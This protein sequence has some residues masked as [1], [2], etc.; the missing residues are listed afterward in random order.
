MILRLLLGL[1]VAASAAAQQ[2]DPTP[3]DPG[4]PTIPTITFTVDWEAATPPW[5]SVTVDSTGSA[6]YEALDQLAKAGDRY[7]VKF[8]V[9][10]PTRERLFHLAERLNYF[11]GDFDFKKHKIAF[12]GAKTLTYA[13]TA[14]RH[15][16][17]YVWSEN[18]ELQEVTDILTGIAATQ[19]SARRLAHLRR[20]DKLGLDAELKGMEEYARYGHLREVQAIAALLREL[21][22]DTQVM[23]ISRQRALRLLKL[24]AAQSPGAADTAP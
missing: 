5:Y 9:S 8:A 1:L 22:N 4:R 21:S 11:Q 12:T 20:F 3:R 17:T 6:M 19:N 10:Q 14:R 16:T 13:H 24:A 2:P 23:K 15:Q 18:P 7:S